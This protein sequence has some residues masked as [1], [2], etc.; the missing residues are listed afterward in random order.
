M[1]KARRKLIEEVEGKLAELIE[2]LSAIK[3][4]E[5]EYRDNMP[6]NLQGSEKYEQADQACSALDDAYNNLE[7]AADYLSTARE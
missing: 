4:E 5:E 3:D 6:E 7:Y 1:N 2:A